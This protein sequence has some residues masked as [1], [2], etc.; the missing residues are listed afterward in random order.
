MPRLARSTT[1]ADR[2]RAGSH[3]SAG[4]VTF[5]KFFKHITNGDMIAERAF[6][7][8]RSRPHGQALNR[9]PS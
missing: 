4:N 3:R 9:K 1:R 5:R 2:I 8:P 6:H 7:R